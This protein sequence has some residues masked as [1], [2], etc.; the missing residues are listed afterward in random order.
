MK[1]SDFFDQLHPGQISTVLMDLL[2]DIITYI[3][4]LDGR[5]VH[6]NRAFAETLQRGA[7]EIVGK[8]DAELFVA[9]LATNYIQDDTT[10]CQSGVPIMEK[11]ELVTHR[12]G[13]VRWYI[14]NKIPLHQRDGQVIGMAGL[15]RPSN[16][17]QRVSGPIASVSKAV[18][19]IY[20]H[21]DESL[22]VDQLA[23]ACGLSISSLERHFKK[24]FGCTPGRFISQVKISAA[25]RMLADTSYSIASVG[26]QLGYPDPVVFSRAFKREMKMTP[27]VYRKSLLA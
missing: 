8:T 3:K 15:S 22:G 1:P 4:D 2:P 20:E 18:D 24:H 21:L 23:D 19:Y 12:P 6:V 16:A 10:V 9:E 5:Y 27:S 26:E 11:A 17:H 25:C 7:D 14:T 13:I